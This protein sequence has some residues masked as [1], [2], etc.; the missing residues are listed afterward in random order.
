MDYKMNWLKEGRVIHLR[1]DGEVTI[2]D[3]TVFNTE[4]RKMLDQGTGKVH[5]IS[6]M[7]EVGKVP[8]NMLKIRE[9]IT[10]F[11]HPNLGWHILINHKN[12]PLSSFLV[13]VAT[14]AAGLQVR[15]VSSFE[16]A[17]STISRIDQTLT[18][19]S[20]SDIKT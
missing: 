3:L 1:I 5:V 7:E 19:F 10:Y 20:L 15:Q 13:T 2:E 8:T 9:V 18:D 16:D 12:N 11:K 14:Q 4:I 6:D 17:V